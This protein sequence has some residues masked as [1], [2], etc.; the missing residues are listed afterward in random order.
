MHFNIHLQYAFFNHEQHHI[1]DIYGTHQKAFWDHSSRMDWRVLKQLW[2]LRDKGNIP[3]FSAA[4]AV[5]QPTVLTADSTLLR[6]MCHCSWHSS[7][8]LFSPHDWPLYKWRGCSHGNTCP[9]PWCE[10]SS[11]AFRHG[12][13][14]SCLH[15]DRSNMT[16][17]GQ[18]GA[19][20]HLY[21]CWVALWRHVC[22]FWKVI[23]YYVHQTFS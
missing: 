4:I 21:Q 17:P 13:P 11:V 6:K 18:A 20:P 19:A 1:C 15:D 7:F 23:I 12:R 14:H 3:Q 2:S 22:G 16:S 10:H 5:S 8:G 9:P